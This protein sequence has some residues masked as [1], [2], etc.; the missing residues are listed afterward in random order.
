MGRIINSNRVERGIPHQP[1]ERRHQFLIQL[2]RK[3]PVEEDLLLRRWRC[4][5]HTPSQTCKRARGWPRP[6]GAITWM[7]MLSR[8]AKHEGSWRDSTRTETPGGG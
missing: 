7:Q 3:L 6:P 5:G 1:K 4:I 8:N 2:P